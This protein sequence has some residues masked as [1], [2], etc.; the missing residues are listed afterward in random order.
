MEFERSFTFLPYAVVFIINSPFTQYTGSIFFM[1]LIVLE[2]VL[3]VIIFVAIWAWWL[4]DL[5]IF[6]TNQ[7]D[8]GNGCMLRENL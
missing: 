3:V 2:T 6:A 1:A 4:A 7:R 8:A 5:I